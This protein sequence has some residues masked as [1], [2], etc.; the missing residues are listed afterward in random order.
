M[1]RST[2]LAVAGACAVLV[3]AGQLP[4]L[5][6]DGAAAAW[7]TS[8]VQAVSNWPKAVRRDARRTAAPAPARAVVR[9]AAAPARFTPARRP[10]F[11]LPDPRGPV[12]PVA[13]G[14]LAGLALG[15]GLLVLI[16]RDGTRKRVFRLARQGRTTARIARDARLPQDAVRAMLTPGV[17][18]RRGR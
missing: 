4:R 15:A 10:A 13:A 11:T 6:W 16:G 2:W 17:G 3:A 9:T 18:A 8:V 5:P 1:K 7:R 12:L 14:T